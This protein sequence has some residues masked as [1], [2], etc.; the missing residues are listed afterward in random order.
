MYENS[1]EIVFFIYI[2]LDYFNI[3]ILKILFKKYILIYFI[4]K[5]VF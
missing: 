5:K 3:L 4:N 1:I 2:F